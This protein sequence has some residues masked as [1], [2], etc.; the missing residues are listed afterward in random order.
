MIDGKSVGTIDKIEKNKVVVNYGIF[1]S[2]VSMEE[3]E[4]VQPILK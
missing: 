1:T 2:K 4:F 3:L